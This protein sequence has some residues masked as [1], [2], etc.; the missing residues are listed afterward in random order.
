MEFEE[1]GHHAKRTVCLAAGAT[2]QWHTVR[3]HRAALG[4]WQHRQCGRWRALRS[5]DGAEHWQP[6]QLPEG[7][8]RSQRPCHRSAIRQIACTL[9]PGRELPD[10]TATAVG[11]FFPK[12]AVKT[13]NRC[14]KKIDTFTTSPSTLEIPTILYAAGFE[15][16]AWRSADRGVTWTR[17]PGFQFQVGT[18]R[19]SRSSGSQQDLHHN[20]RRQ[21]VAR[22]HQW[23]AN[24]GRH[25]HA[26]PRTWTIAFARGTGGG[27][28][29]NRRQWLYGVGVMA[30]AGMQLGS[31]SPQNRPRAK[32]T[33]TPLR[34]LSIRA[35]EHV[36]GAR[37]ARRAGEVSGDRFSHAHLG[38]CRSR[39]KA[40]NSRRTVSIWARR[41]S[42]WR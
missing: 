31:A 34:P 6:V 14:L 1:Q 5:T 15:S 21:R 20:V 24:A 17:I 25:R 32:P 19:D 40:S 26:R 37:D 27:N 9:Q 36:A 41:R 28:L 2:F 22:L 38:L 39:R 8:E 16:S 10:N 30:G 23:R 7:S 42:C 13:G 3:V 11:F 35:E 18:A 12:M 33:P 29:I 4:R